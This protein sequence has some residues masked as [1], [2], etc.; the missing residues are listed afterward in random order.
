MV[1]YSC[2]RH[3]FLLI[4]IIGCCFLLYQYRQWKSYFLT[5]EHRIYTSLLIELPRLERR[6]R[7]EQANLSFVR[8]QLA[9]VEKSLT[10]H[11]WHLGRL[12]KTLEAY[13]QEEKR[14]FRSNT[15]DFDLEKSNEKNSTKFLVYFHRVN[16]LDG[17][18]PTISE[19]FHSKLSTLSSP[20]LT[21]NQSEA[22]L[23]L[24]YLP[25][26]SGNK[27]TCYK[28]RIDRSFFVLYEL[29]G[30][31]TGDFADECFLGNFIQVK[32]F[33]QSNRTRTD[34]DQWRFAHEQPI[35]LGMI[36]LHNN[37][38]FDQ[39]F[40]SSIFNGVEFFSYSLSRRLS[41]IAKAIRCQC[42][43]SSSIVLSNDLREEYF[44]DFDRVS[45]VLFDRSSKSIR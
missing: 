20:Y 26:R 35:S 8:N 2:R 21:F 28:D 11:S 12:I 45:I 5:D 17:V 39:R 32:F 36:Y 9:K 30:D 19:I 40:R 27:S 37:G 42:R 7:D 29:I 1:T 23:H 38:E 25:I 44:D 34:N 14:V 31:V 18:D 13:R 24:V 41:S 15:F 16:L 22:Y 43:M 3:A 33:T 4:G 10:K 6:I